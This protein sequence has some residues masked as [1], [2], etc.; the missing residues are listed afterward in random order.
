L[1]LGLVNRETGQVP[2]PLSR[3][4]ADLLAFL[5]GAATTAAA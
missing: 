5:K 2:G 3:W 1:P 4:S